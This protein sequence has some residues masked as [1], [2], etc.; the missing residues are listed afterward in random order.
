[1]V[2]VTNRHS[3]QAQYMNA[4]I[5][6]SDKKFVITAAMTGHKNKNFNI[7]SYFTVIRV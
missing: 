2:K 6:E 7:I 4:I 1:M 3:P 5:W